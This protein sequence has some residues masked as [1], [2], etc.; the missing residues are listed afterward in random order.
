MDKCQFPV[1]TVILAGGRGVRIGGGKGL[2]VLH[3][4]PLIGWVLAAVS[5]DSAEV[6]I[7]AN[8]TQELFGIFDRPVIG[9]QMQGWQGPLAGLHAALLHAQ[10][11][12]VLTVPCDTPFLPHDLI[13]RLRDG[14]NCLDAEAVVVVAGGYR[15]PAIA[16]YRKNVQPKLIAFLESGGRKVNDWL[17]T[18]KLNE[19][20]FENADEF[21][22]I[23][24]REEL[25]L[26]IQM[27]KSVQSEL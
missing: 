11:N 17:D 24:T 21:E 27:V 12:H 2:Q 14:F 7:N 26:A 13:A 15:Q 16:L 25:E 18:L 4:K 6:L 8:E 9:D 23:N 3:D 19:V 10:N 22:N 1:T 20:V 5:R